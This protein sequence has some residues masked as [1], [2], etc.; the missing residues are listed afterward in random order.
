MRGR[1]PDDECPPLPDDEQGRTRPGPR[2]SPILR[3][4]RPNAPPILRIARPNALLRIARPN[5][6]L[7]IARPNA[8]L[9]ITQGR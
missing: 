9:W 6:L 3:I 2:E 7:W 4:A 1:L 5:A 8:L